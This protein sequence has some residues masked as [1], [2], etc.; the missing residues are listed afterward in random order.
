MPKTDVPQSS[1]VVSEYVVAVSFCTE[2]EHSHNVYVTSP[3]TDWTMEHAD[4]GMSVVGVGTKA[5][6]RAIEAKNGAIRAKKADVALLM[7]LKR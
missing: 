4:A 7:M 3:V 5:D 2:P 1:A 6:E